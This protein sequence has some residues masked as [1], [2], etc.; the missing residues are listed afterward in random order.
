MTLQILKGIVSSQECSSTFKVC[1]LHS[2][3]PKSKFHNKK[4][5]VLDLI[6][7]MYSGV[8]MY[9]FSLFVLQKKYSST[10]LHSAINKGKRGR[11]CI[12]KQGD[13]IVNDRRKCANL[14]SKEKISP[15]FRQ[16]DREALT[17]KTWRVLHTFTRLKNQRLYRLTFPEN[18]F[19]FINL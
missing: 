18:I 15:I 5:A 16:L 2:K 12:T 10:D 7:H 9:R 11:N 1:Y 4:I 8:F 13:L 19:F 6:L 14:I 3:Y 17:P